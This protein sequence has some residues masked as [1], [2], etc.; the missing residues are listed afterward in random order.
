MEANDMTIQPSAER[1]PRRAQN[2]HEVRRAETDART[3][4]GCLEATGPAILTLPFDDG[5]A[6]PAAQASL[7]PSERVHRDAHPSVRILVDVHYA[8]K[9]LSCGRTY[10]YELIKRGD[11]PVVKLGRLT[12]IPIEALEAFVARQWNAAVSS[13][14]TARPSP[15]PPS[16][17]WS[18]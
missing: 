14:R 18:S 11:L 1:A 12:R 10:V 7:T 15:S 9:A 6:E 16:A 13:A 17:P 3:R 5:P 8:M 2:Q 4:A